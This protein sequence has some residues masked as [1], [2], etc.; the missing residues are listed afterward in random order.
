MAT[1]IPKNKIS[2]RGVLPEDVKRWI[3]ENTSELTP[4]QMAEKLNVNVSRVLPVLDNY[5]GVLLDK[6]FMWRERLKKT[7]AWRHIKNEF[8]AD[9]L[10][11]FSDKYIQLMEQ[12]K[13]DVLPTEEQ[14][15]ISLIRVEIMQHRNL[16]GRKQLG[17]SNNRIQGMI[18][19]LLR[20][21]NGNMAQLDETDRDR[22]IELQNQQATLENSQNL[23]TKEFLELGKEH[24]SLTEKLKASRVQRINAAT[25]DKLTWPELVKML[26]DRKN[27]EAESRKYELQRV[28]A[29]KELE[30][31]TKPHRFMDNNVDV[32]I[33]NYES[34]DN[35][36]NIDELTGDENNVE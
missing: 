2:V 12:F 28:A 33:L 18:D 13:E 9:E 27:Q 31:L 23:K 10:E 30:R 24:S 5:N 6:N 16:V 35:L 1:P 34:M 15:I 22:I 17:D 4:E 26:M 25:N 7:K 21:V 36:N 11:Y 14:Q 20:A 32:P 3:L 19:D 29:E 8:T